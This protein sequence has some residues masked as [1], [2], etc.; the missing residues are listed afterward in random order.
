LL[1]VAGGGF[2]PPPRFVQPTM[3]SFH[4][5]RLKGMT[6][7]ATET[8]NQRSATSVREG[9]EASKE[10]VRE[11]PLSAAL[12]VFGLGFAVGVAVGVLLSEEDSRRFEASNWE[13]YGR[14]MLSALSQAVPEAV[15]RRL[16]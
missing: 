5:F 2:A 15:S 4:V 9:Y 6:R 14:Q 7:M 8:S 3:F 10:M 16:S 11:H 12:T 13:R 1:N